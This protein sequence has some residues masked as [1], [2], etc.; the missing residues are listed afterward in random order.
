MQQNS[1]RATLVKEIGL[2]LKL[3]QAVSVPGEQAVTADD[4][5]VWW[6]HR[7]WGHRKN[8]FDNLVLHR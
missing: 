7:A 6:G 8:H 2:F 4:E 1:I 3:L 5:E